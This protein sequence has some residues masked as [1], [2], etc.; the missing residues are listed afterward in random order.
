MSTD[1]KIHALRRTWAGDDA[2]VAIC[3]LAL[4]GV[5]P[6]A[7]EWAAI[8]RDP[9]IGL[10]EGSTQESARK[11]CVETIALRELEEEQGNLFGR[12]LARG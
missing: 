2:Y 1:P 7:E 5:G 10:Y 8:E 3:D 6:T 11:W 9:K 12:P 4:D